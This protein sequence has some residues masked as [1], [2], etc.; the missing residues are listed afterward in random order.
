M[1]Y[2]LVMTHIAMEKSS[3]S[4]ENSLCL[5]S[6]SKANCWFTRGYSMSLFNF[7][8]YIYIYRIRQSRIFNSTVDVLTLFGG[9]NTKL[10]YMMN[11]MTWMMVPG[12]PE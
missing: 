3:Y 9:L 2:P 11:L 10:I 7:D 8:I 4:L 6:C 1:N 12:Y 5:W